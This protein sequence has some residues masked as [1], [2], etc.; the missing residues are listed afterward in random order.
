MAAVLRRKMFNTVL[1]SCV[2]LAC[3]VVVFAQQQYGIE[4]KDSEYMEQNPR[5]GCEKISITLCKDIAYNLTKMPNMLQHQ[6][7]EDA[8]MEVH[9]F[10]PLV[11]VNCS[12]QL[13]FF[14]C[15]I[16]V[17]LCTQLDEPLPP[18][19]SLCIE[20]RTGCEAL[21]NKFGFEWPTSL[22]CERFPK[23]GLCVGQ[24]KTQHSDST[25]KPG[26]GAGGGGGGDVYTDPGTGD[27]DY[28]G[29][30]GNW[31]GWQGNY[32]GTLSKG[33][34]YDKGKFFLKC[35]QVVACSMTSPHCC[36]NLD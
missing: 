17:P 24:N 36:W 4:D 15:T 1:F 34:L 11:K 27:G 14:L 5:K 21:M 9:Q 19:R 20:A 6:K 13:K 31:N 29:G 32:G 23:K 28:G 35:F 16:Y 18:C 12:K 22:K 33:G 8:G 7:Q 26:T 10:F 3:N 25:K 30:I 2:I